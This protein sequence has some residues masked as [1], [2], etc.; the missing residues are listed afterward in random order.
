VVLEGHT[1]SLRWTQPLAAD[2]KLV[3]HGARQRLRSD[4][5]IA[6]PFGCFSPDP[7]PDGTYYADRYCPD[8]SFD[9]YDFRSDNERRWSDALD[10]SVSGRVEAAGLVHRL[11][12]GVLHQTVPARF[13]RQAFNFAGTGHVD[14]S[15]VLPA[16][17]DLT[18]ENTN[19]DE[20]STELY[21]RD[22]VVFAPGWTAWFGWRHTRLHRDSVRTDGSQP[23][24]YTQSIDTPFA[25]LSFAFASGQLVYASAGRGIETDVAPNRD[26]YTNAGV[27]LPA[28]RSRQLELGLKGGI[29]AWSWNAAWFDIRRPLAVDVG[30]CD[31]AGSCTRVIDGAQRHRGAEASLEWRD[32]DWAVQAAAMALRARREDS[33][34]A[35]ANSLVPTNV[36]QRTLKAQADYR[37]APALTASLG[38][39]HEGRRYVTPDNSA[40]IPAWTRIDAG[41]AWEQLRGR[42][43]MTWRLGIDNLFDRRAWKE[44]PYQFG[45]AYLYPLAARTVRLSVQVDL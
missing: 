13:Q 21:A 16:A 23:T 3:V 20:R 39:V 27:A 11:G 26:R 40:R 25:A 9:L 2:W 4:D 10:V 18:G 19:R 34:D 35:A 5:R 17:P 43:V 36:P 45:H 1:A 6:F 29:E 31:V 37:V 28:L 32:G 33:A 14:G 44:S 15:V 38:L 7:A 42:S 24:G 30:A 12:V 22:A 41:A 8:G